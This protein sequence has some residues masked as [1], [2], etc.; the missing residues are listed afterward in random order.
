MLLA[1]MTTIMASAQTELTSDEAKTL[2]KNTTKS[3]VSVHDPSVVYEPNTKRYYIFGSHKAGAYT[4][5]LDTSQPN[6]DS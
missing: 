6:V 2:Y 5:E 4:T 1:T 3:R